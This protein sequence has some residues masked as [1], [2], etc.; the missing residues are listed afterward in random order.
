MIWY[1][2]H[3]STYR[4][5]HSRASG[6]Q[7]RSN[8][9]VG[10]EAEDHKNDMGYGAIASPDNLKKRMRVG[11]SSLQLNSN[12]SEQNDLDSRSGSVPERPRYTISIGDSAGLEKC[13]CPG[14]R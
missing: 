10:K 1:H 9:D 4:C 8:K 13:G 3:R 12:G 5:Y 11:S 14:P 2:N 6:Q 7:H